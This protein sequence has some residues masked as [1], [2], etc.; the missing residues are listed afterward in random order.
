MAKSGD[1]G[2]QCLASVG[3]MREG[4]TGRMNC[5]ESERRRSL[6]FSFL[7]KERNDMDRVREGDYVESSV[8]KS[9][10]SGIYRREI[11]K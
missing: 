1:S 4:V 5:V 6:F 11:T 2:S 8:E 9:L 7:G 10:C 3:P